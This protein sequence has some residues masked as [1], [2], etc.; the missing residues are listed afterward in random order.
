MPCASTAAAACANNEYGVACDCLYDYETGAVMIG[1]ATEAWRLIEDHLGPPAQESPDGLEAVYFCPLS[2]QQWLSDHPD[3]TGQ[4]P[5]QMRIRIVHAQPPWW[6]PPPKVM[7]KYSPGICEVICCE[8]GDDPDLD[9]RDVSIQL[10][11]IRGPY[12]D[13]AGDD[14]AEEHARYHRQ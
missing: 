9:Y 1:R 2:G 8:C 7:C 4:N 14:A 5:G 11:R 12:P 10:Q 6:T 13:A 3:R